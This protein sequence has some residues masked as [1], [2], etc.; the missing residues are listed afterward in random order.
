MVFPFFVSV[1]LRKKGSIVS[2]ESPSSS[3][4]RAGDQAGPAILQVL[5]RLETGGVE[6]GTVEIAEALRDAGAL[7][8]VV[9]AGGVLERE[10]ERLDAVHVRLP[11]HSKNPLTMWRNVE[12][13]A[14]VIRR[15]DVKL[16]HARSRA[17]AWSAR[18]AARRCGVPF[19]TT[20][21]GTYN[22]GPFGIKAPYNAVMA[23][24][25]RVIAISQFIARHVQELYKVPPDRIRV[26][27]RGVDLTRFDP[28]H[29]S[30]ERMIK[31]ANDWRLPEDL[32]VVMLPG[33]LTRWKGQHVV[34]EAL[35]R[36]GRTDLR[37]LLVGSDQGRSRYRATL[38]RA[39]ADKGLQGVVHIVNGCNDMAAAYLLTDYVISAS[40]DPEAFGRVIV[41]AQAMGRPVIA[42]R[43]GGALETVTPGQ[44]GWL[45]APGDPG[46]LAEA[47]A[48]ALA[49]PA[50][51]RARMAAACQE[52]ARGTYSKRQM[53]DKTLDVYAEL[54]TPAADS[55]PAEAR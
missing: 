9:S 18:A 45:V 16:V 42:T 29:V 28:A 32:P 11:V 25:D 31:L 8:V 40:T 49:V 4:R 46:E 22:R 13:I 20:F 12:A 7:P 34:I 44:T 48:A 10:L 27:P 23:S 55:P 2:S 6:R 33:R 30:P 54:L 14:E 53:C 15:Y 17:P 50:A 47:I 26:I 5:P 24:G 52:Q 3:S 51:E 37:C 1:V 43:H 41:E 38:E 36:L 35:A 21:H 19:V 39:I